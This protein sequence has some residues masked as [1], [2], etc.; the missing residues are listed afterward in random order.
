M[1]VD[2]DLVI[3]KENFKLIELNVICSICNGIV[4]APV[5]CIECE[6]CF[7]KSCIES[8]KKKAGENSCPFR[9]KSPIF[10]NSRLIKNILSNIKFKCQ[11]GC[12]QE[13]PYLE[14]ENHYEENCPNIKVDY[15]QKY[16]EMK[17]KYLELLKK[18]NELENEFIKYKNNSSNNHIGNDYKSQYH[19]HILKN[20]IMNKQCVC[21]VC[22]CVIRDK[23]E[24]TYRCD[25][26]DF[27]VCEKC[28]ILEDSGYKY[29]NL[30]LSKKHSHLLKEIDAK[31][32]SIF[33]YFWTCD[34]CGNKFK[35]K[36]EVR[37]FRCNPCDYDICDSCKIKEENA[38][39][40]LNIQLNNMHIE[41]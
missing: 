41:D 36:Q 19:N 27:D 4:V 8:W 31:S 7:C 35:G 24:K 29:K 33:K 1:Y 28:K 32:V 11:N 22:D 37:R 23:E 2:P 6:N 14:L 26:C 25:E 21:D 34:V 3:N 18:Y 9:C 16:Y 39:N 12:N 40:H 5:Q 20:K 13:I 15:K 38:V 30:F 17:N 10:K